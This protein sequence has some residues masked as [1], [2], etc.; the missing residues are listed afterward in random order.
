MFQRT[1]LA[2]ALSLVAGSLAAQISTTPQQ[3][4][5]EHTPRH[6]SIVDARI[7]IA[8]GKVIENGSV[9]VRD[10]LIV[11]VRAGR[12]E[13][14]GAVILEAHG[15]TVFPAFIDVHGS[16]GFDGKARCPTSEAARGGPG[17]G[18]GGRGGFGGG[19]SASAPIAPAA[20]HW[21]DRVC[22]ERDVSRNLALDADSAKVLRHLGF[23][24][25]VAAPGSG[26][27]RGQSA[28][29][30][31]RDQ[32]TPQ[33]NLLAR[34][35]AQYAAFEADFSFGGVYP[36]SKMG[37]IALIRQAFLDAG[38]QRDLLAWQQK[39]GGE[40]AEANSALDALLPV[41]DGQQAMVFDADDELDVVRAARIAAEFGLQ[42]AWVLGTGNEYRVLDQLPD[43]IGM[44]LPLNFPKAP[45]VSDAEAALELSLAELEQWRY[46]PYNPAK[47]AASG[48]PYALTLAGL[49]K[50]DA[51]FWP[52]LRKAV[53]YGLSADQALAALTI[54]PA[55]FLGAQGK[56][57]EI[58]A[59]QPAN[60]LI[61]DATLFSADDAQI[62]EVW[63]D[64]ARD[65]IKALDAPEIAGL[66][67]VN[68]MGAS[69]P[70]EWI[71]E[72][73]P[74]ALKIK[75]GEHEASAKLNKG[76]L[77][78]TAPGEWF[79]AEQKATLEAALS[80]GK[81]DGRWLSEDGRVRNWSAMR[82]G[83]APEPTEKQEDSD[84]D[85]GR[86]GPG[87]A[88]NNEAVPAFPTQARYPA[89]DFGRVGL[90]PQIDALVIRDATVW[91]TGGSEPLTETDVLVE[92]GRISDVGPDLPAPRGAI[93]VDGRGL[94]LTPGLID[95]HSH[96][97]GSGN[98]NEPSHAITSE[99]RLGDIVDPTD[100]N[101]YRELAGG[102]TTSHVL[103]GSANP[104]G[105]QSQ[106]VKHRW[107]AGAEDLKFAGA[108]PTI[109]FA[110]GEN[111]KQSNWGPVAVPR[112]PQTRMG[113]EQLLKDAFVQARAYE[114][115]RASKKGPPQRRD[116]RMEA[117]VEIL[118]HQRLVHIHSY[119][120]DE[121]LMFARLS[122][123]LGIKVAAFQHVLEGY[124][125]AEVLAEVGAGASTFSD[126]WSFK[127]EA[128]DAI[129][130]NA[131]IM[132]GQGVLTSLNSDSNDLGRRL[133]TEAGKAGR[134]GGLSDTEALALVTRNPAQQLRVGDRVG[135]IKAGMDADLVLWSHHPLSSYA[136]PRKVWIDGREY[137]DQAADQAEQQ[138]IVAARAELV[139]AALAEAPKGGAPGG[140][141]GPGKP[142]L[143]IDPTRYAVLNS[144]LAAL[145]GAYHNG[146]AVHYCQGEH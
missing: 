117:L 78:I 137:F 40:R 83:A 60:L 112:Y 99:V 17:S 111:V 53:K 5:A 44:L 142:R 102:T 33:Q 68:W 52:A 119:R 58:K 74:D 71:I 27:L 82:T 1:A 120:Q 89:G 95:A 113:V 7:V 126:W 121:I 80:A 35:V 100:I 2:V 85:A 31:L 132:M 50:P 8:P 98:I 65:Q 131:A 90:P 16:Y 140:P 70:A 125:V 133:N 75:S 4:L 96:I 62:F 122:A 19:G 134:Y 45:A 129:P 26:V 67:A 128:V 63:A 59:G 143:L 109:K 43:G 20:R 107:G 141:G 79:G 76:R 97:A 15:K 14:P 25:S 42:R 41:L 87:L 56:L 28:L 57:G 73:K 3:G 21:N 66:W 108:T 13:A 104:I 81:L 106:L 24:A 110:L 103:H 93:E 54:H 29:L 6:T 72:G 86:G 101:I 124:K 51:E 84:K 69:G 144:R 139:Q 123:E 39:N 135:S 114:T 48:H 136:R 55:R 118:N 138:R 77:L 10:G 115:A 116:L 91:M 12:R 18:R 32:P 130:Y 92:R 47:V 9:E 49:D 94:H 37:A 46:A 38:W 127:M 88:D 30:S 23:A 145:R 105:G 34:R 11:D 64:G 61:A 146:E 36:G 22:P